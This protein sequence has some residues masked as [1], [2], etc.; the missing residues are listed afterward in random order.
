MARVAQ[1]LGPMALLASAAMVAAVVL[2][3]PLA[4]LVA[5]LA[6]LVRIRRFGQPILAASPMVPVLRAAPLHLNRQRAVLLKMA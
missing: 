2:V 3:A 5:E 1:A 4:V 6:A